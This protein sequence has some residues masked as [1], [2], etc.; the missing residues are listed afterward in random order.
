MR[1]FGWAV[2]SPKAADTDE[3]HLE[4]KHIVNV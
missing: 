4:M 3:F 1:G 2:A